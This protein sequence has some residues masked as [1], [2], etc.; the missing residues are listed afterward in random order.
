LED[1]GIRDKFKVIVGG[2]PTNGKWAKDI[3]ADGWAE[4]STDAVELCNQLMGVK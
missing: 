2:A 1:K 3:G 4:N